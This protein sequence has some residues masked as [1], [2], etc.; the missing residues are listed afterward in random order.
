[1]WRCV[2]PVCLLVIAW[3]FPLEARKSDPAAVDSLLAAA[4]HPALRDKERV[5]LVKEAMRYD[6]SGR[7][8][9][10]LAL[11]YIKKGSRTAIYDA[12]LW[13]KRAIARERH[14]PPAHFAW[15]SIALGDVE[16]AVASVEQAYENQD[17]ILPFFFNWPWPQIDDFKK[18]SRI[19]SVMQK[20][21]LK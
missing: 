6:R 4:S 16:E 2:Y 12:E 8:M 17:P 1:M 20:M 9:H 3:A 18:D 10:V 14:V 15:T 19:Q 13:L 5:K 11:L 21:G 7:A